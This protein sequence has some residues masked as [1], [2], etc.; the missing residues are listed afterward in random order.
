MVLFLIGAR[1][2]KQR[3]HGTRFLFLRD[4]SCRINVGF[5]PSSTTKFGW[6]K[7]HGLDSSESDDGHSNSKASL[8]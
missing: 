3:V 6:P 4:L 1:G 7:G 5:Q 2:T 8:G